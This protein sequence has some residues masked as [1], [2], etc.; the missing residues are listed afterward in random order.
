[1]VGAIAHIDPDLYK[2]KREEILQEER[3]LSLGGSTILSDKEEAVNNCLMQRKFAEADYSFDNPQYFN[4]SHHYFF[5]KDKIKDSRVYQIIKSMPKGAALH[6]HDMAML[7]PD[8]LLN[9][10]YMDYLYVCFSKDKV[11]FKFSNETPKTICSGHW[12]EMKEARRKSAN[13]KE[14]DA[15]LRKH[16]TIVT[17]DPYHIYTDI[18]RIWKVFMD[19]FITVAPMLS[20]RPVWGQ[21]FY[22]ALKKFREDGIMYVEV[23]SV[24]PNL[25]EL[26]GTVYDAL[27]TAK[28]Y[29]K[30]IKRF[31]QDYPDFIG[32]KL[33]YAPSRLVNQQTVQEYIRIAKKIKDDMPEI[34]AGFDLVGQEDLG[35]PL[36]KFLPTLL[37]ASKYLNFYFHAGET[38]WYGTATD[39]NIVDAILLGAKRLG[40]AYALTKHPILMKEVLNRTIGLEVNVVSNEVL[41][42][43][44]DVRNHPLAT[45]LAE[46]MPVVISSDDP[47]A[48]EA[49]PISHDFYIAFQGVASRLA[50]LRLLKT[51]AINSLRYSA[52]EENNKNQAINRFHNKWQLFIENFNC[53]DYIQEY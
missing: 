35:G 48:W 34:F 27:I 3:L 38:N 25:Y 20:Y 32:A 53:S 42:L 36:V 17:K 52:L 24:L 1:M 19:Y 4:F 16:F 26:D 14:F 29:R 9:I 21:Y 49:E 6:V 45:F 7:G 28:A 8:Y 10:T 15:N 47:G 33:I 2:S 23:R 37:D 46:G 30:A 40:H 41:D 31:I 44:Q 22:D 12:E 11:E 51:L 50:D 39:D 43:V 5:Y 13:V 18:N